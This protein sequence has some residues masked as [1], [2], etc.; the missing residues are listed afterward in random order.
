MSKPTNVS[1]RYL[2]PSI[3]LQIHSGCGCAANTF[4]SSATAAHSEEEE[5]RMFSGHLNCSTD[6]WMTAWMDYRLLWTQTHILSWKVSL[7]VLSKDHGSVIWQEQR[8]LLSNQ[9]CCIFRNTTIFH[10]GWDRCR[11]VEWAIWPSLRT[12]EV[13]K[14]RFWV[15]R[16]KHL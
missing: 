6:F 1:L 12:V 5:K 14:V 15:L 9:I 7:A 10:L 11:R 3:S 4:S 8:C 16:L 13:E 2:L